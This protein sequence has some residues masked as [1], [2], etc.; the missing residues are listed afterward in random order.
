LSNEILANIERNER[1]ANATHYEAIGSLMARLSIR[2]TSAMLRQAERLDDL[3]FEE[4]E[5]EVIEAEKSFYGWPEESNLPKYNHSIDHKVEHTQKCCHSSPKCRRFL[6]NF[7]STRF[8]HL[9][10]CT[11]PLLLISTFNWTMTTKISEYAWLGVFACSMA[12]MISQ[13]LNLFMSRPIRIIDSEH[14]WSIV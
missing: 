6:E 1:L 5:K 7:S 2:P 8:W 14:V 11:F 9:C 12:S 10:F 13:L 3:K 4:R